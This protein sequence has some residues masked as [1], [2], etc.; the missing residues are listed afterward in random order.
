MADGVSGLLPKKYRVTLIKASTSEIMGIY[1]F[2]ED[3]LP[4]KFDK[5]TLLE[6]DGKIWRVLEVNVVREA[7]YL[8]SK[9]LEL[10]V[11]A[12]EALD[13]SGKYAVPTNAFS[14]MKHINNDFERT[15]FAMAEY[16][17]R[18]Y[19][20]LSV[21]QIP[22]IQ[23]EIESIHRI[24]NPEIP[25]N[26]LLGYNVIHS[27][28]IKLNNSLSIPFQDFAALIGVDE[29]GTVS[30][31]EDYIIENGFSLRSESYLYYGR[32]I[33]GAIVELAIHGFES[34]DDEVIQITNRFG[35]VLV[36]WCNAHMLM[37]PP[38]DAPEKNIVN[39]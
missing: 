17:W 19:E 11:E 20:F 24:I 6:A 4:E 13:L 18:Q 35:L 25:V 38:N 26:T 5:P 12:P 23:E 14:Q 15:V 8:S 34:V 22:L 37:A 21:A 33:D 39:F 10:Q 31:M 30:I 36:D 28:S 7:S 1:R 29:Q 16:D 32:I 2:R 3:Q 27:R 9:K